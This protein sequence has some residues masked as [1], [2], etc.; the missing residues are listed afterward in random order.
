MASSISQERVKVRVG[1]NLYWYKADLCH[2][3]A[4]NSLR[5]EMQP[6]KSNS[7]AFAPLH[8]L[9]INK[10]ERSLRNSDHIMKPL[11]KVLTTWASL[12]FVEIHN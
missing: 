2:H 4:L 11:E 12:K 1:F 9:W 6:L 5:F 8:H 3:V 10:F 7:K